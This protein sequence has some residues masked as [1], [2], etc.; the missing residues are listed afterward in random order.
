MGPRPD[1]PPLNS[2]ANRLTQQRQP[3]QLILPPINR[4]Q[5]IQANR[6]KKSMQFI[7]FNYL[8]QKEQKTQCKFN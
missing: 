5:P 1:L 7:G 2:A 8:Y 6:S 4:F 3:Q